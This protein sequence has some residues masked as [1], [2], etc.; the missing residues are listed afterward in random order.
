MKKAVKRRDRK[1]L[2]CGRTS[3][4]QVDHIRPRYHG[5]DHSED[6]LQLLCSVCNALK[7]TR[8]INFRDEVTS[9][10]SAE[11]VR[12]SADWIFRRTGSRASDGPMILLERMTNMA[13]QCQ[14][15]AEI[16][17][18]PASAARPYACYEVRVKAGNDPAWVQPILDQA[19][20]LWKREVPDFGRL[21]GGMVLAVAP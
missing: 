4:L 20:A 7:G 21:Y 6:N 14:A 16:R 10:T 15:C 1:C 19:L 5:G 8:N 2:C 17:R 12:A 13:Y 11:E 18:L 9:L 3:F